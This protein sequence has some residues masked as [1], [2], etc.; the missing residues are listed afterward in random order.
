MTDYTPTTERV[1]QR[2]LE[3]YEYERDMPGRIRERYPDEVLAMFDR[4]L[5]AHDAEIVATGQRAVDAHMQKIAHRVM[6][7][8]EEADEDTLADDI[9]QDI[10]AAVGIV[11]VFTNGDET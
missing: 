3:A 10:F 9:M 11:E 1:R 4:W 7:V 2:W 8:F 6:D 5:A